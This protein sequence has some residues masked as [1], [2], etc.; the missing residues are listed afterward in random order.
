MLSR[1][2][3]FLLLVFCFLC[4]QGQI[5]CRSGEECLLMWPFQRARESESSLRLWG[6]CFDSSPSCLS[7][8]NFLSHYKLVDGNYFPISMVCLR[9]NCP[10]PV[11]LFQ[12]TMHL[13]PLSGVLFSSTTSDGQVDGLPNTCI[14]KCINWI[15]PLTSGPF[16]LP[17]P[18]SV[19]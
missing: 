13:L 7:T 4:H 14:V 16:I 18:S 9:L 2:I 8:V 5:H 17:A 3:V 12:L 19:M 15:D 6:W 1:W 10:R 11:N